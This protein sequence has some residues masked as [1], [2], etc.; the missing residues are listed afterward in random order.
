MVLI[1]ITIKEKQNEKGSLVVDG[2]L[3][4]KDCSGVQH[5][6]SIP[7]GKAAAMTPSEVNYWLMKPL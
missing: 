6:V 1:K 3:V 7:L 4:R 2:A 5:E